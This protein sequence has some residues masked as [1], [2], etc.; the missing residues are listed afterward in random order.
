MDRDTYFNRACIRVTR[1]GSLNTQA[2]KRAEQSTGA[3]WFPFPT[4][5]KCTTTNQDNT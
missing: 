3:L 4:T 5:E 1:C 2:L